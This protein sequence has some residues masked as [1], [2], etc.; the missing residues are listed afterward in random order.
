MASSLWSSSGGGARPK[1]IKEAD[2]EKCRKW[3]NNKTVT[4]T[5]AKLPGLDEVTTEYELYQYLKDGTELCRVIGL[6]TSKHVLEG[7]TYRTNNI[8]NLEEKNVKLFISYVERE[9]KLQ[10]I[11]GSRNE[12]VFRKFESFYKVLEGLSKISK[13]LERKINVPGFDGVR[14]G[15]TLTY[16]AEDEDEINVVYEKLYNDDEKMDQIYGEYIGCKDPTDLDEAMNEMTQVNQSFIKR[17]LKN[18]K[19]NFVEKNTNTLL[20]E[21]FFPSLKINNLLLLHEDLDKEFET[22]N[23]SYINIGSIF[24]NF[25]DKFLIYCSVSSKLKTMQEFLADQMANNIDIR[26]SISGLEKSAGKS[27]VGKDDRNVCKIQ[28]LMGMIP[29]HIMRYPMML[30]Q[31]QKYAEK[32]SRKD[33]VKET[34]KAWCIM[35]NIMK[36]IERYI[37][38]YNYIETMANLKTDMKDV[39]VTNL[40]SFGVLNFEV[41]EVEMKLVS[42]DKYRPFQLLCFDHF[43]VASELYNEEHFEGLTLMGNLKVSYSKIKRFFKIFKMKDFHEIRRADTKTHITLHLKSFDGIHMDNQKSITLKFPIKKEKQA[44]IL[45]DQFEELRMKADQKIDSGTAHNLHECELYRKEVIENVD[46]EVH[47]KCADCGEFLLGKLQTGIKCITCNGVFHEECFKSDKETIYGEESLDHPEDLLIIPVDLISDYDMGTAS[48]AVAE[49]LLA[50]KPMGT[51]LLRYSQRKGQYVISRKL[52]LNDPG[53]RPNTNVFAHHLINQQEIYGTMY[54][55]MEHGE[56]RTTVFE[57]V[58]NHRKSHRLYIPI[59]NSE[60][61]DATQIM[62]LVGNNEPAYTESRPV[63]RMLNTDFHHQTPFNDYH[64]GDMKKEEAEKILKNEPEGKFILRNNDG[65]RISRVPC[66]NGSRI[67]HFIIH[68][69]KVGQFSVSKLKKFWTIEDLIENY[70]NMD[71]KHKYWLGEPFLNKMALDRLKPENLTDEEMICRRH[72]S[73]RK[74]PYSLPYFHGSMSK[75]EAQKIL[76]QEPSGT[77]LLRNNDKN[78]Y[79]LSHK[80]SSRIEHIRI[81]YQTNYTVECITGEFSSIRRLVEKLKE[82]NFFNNGLKS[83]LHWSKKSS[84]S[85]SPNTEF[86]E[87]STDRQRTGENEDRTRPSLNVF[88]EVERM[89]NNTPSTTVNNNQSRTIVNKERTKRPEMQRTESE[90]LDVSLVNKLKV[91]MKDKKDKVIQ[92]KKKVRPESPQL[93]VRSTTKDVPVMSSKEAEKRI[94]EQPVGTW[95]LRLNEMREKRITILRET[96]VHI[97]LFEFPGELFS[98]R[99]NSNERQPLQSLLRDL[100]DSGTI[101]RRYDL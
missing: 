86:S 65:Y 15:Q 24:E 17:V 55:W 56:G 43:I 71:E 72:S 30:A 29:Q 3:L 6:I 44:M 85:V 89:D 18:L 87:N 38:D 10:N 33:V 67:R 57:V 5:S 64:H 58:E 20:C 50:D 14:K 46:E 48:K 68:T 36:H 53:T 96:V 81:S 8:S 52:H 2:W 21:N 51:F 19:T 9:L 82:N 98:L 32:E 91:F 25:R 47:Q 49:D 41:D 39:P 83:N 42:E 69:D 90:S 100:Q 40:H 76:I 37:Y 92:Q 13:Q 101:G 77:F 1:E 61:E 94:K 26:E 66:S 62:E 78:E 60:A 4:P 16:E 12:Q 31:I 88:E 35:N 7:I 74:E 97:R 22:M 23:V 93:G 80:R 63:S 28:E 73:K 27:I 34:R 54:Y 95:I 70:Q 75:S 45:Y 79:R 99:Q 84:T 11:F 59:N